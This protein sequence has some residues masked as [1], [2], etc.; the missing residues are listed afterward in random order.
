VL[1]SLPGVPFEMQHL[2]EQVVCKLQERFA[3]A[4]IYHRNL[5]TFGLPEATLAEQLAAWE[6]ALPSYIKLAYL[7][8]PVSGI[9]L[10][11]SVYDKLSVVVQQEVEHQVTALK[12]L[13]GNILYGEELDSLQAVSGRL[14]QAKGATVATA[15]SCTGG[16]IASLITS[17][18]G[19]SA[20]FKGSVIA[21]DNNVKINVLGVAKDSLTLN[22]AVSSEVV[23][24]MAEGARRL[25]QTDY[26]VA[27]SGIAGPDGGTPEKPVG[28]VWTAVASPKGTKTEL[29]HTIGDRQ[30]IIER[31]AANALNLLRLELDY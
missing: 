3:L 27:T 6:N 16:K 5:M 1:I 7:P 30:R 23:Q 24:Q 19:S 13:L 25:L 11:L 10:R 15:E 2:M 28:T 12:Q 21:Y 9:K 4:P 22:G 14:L 17:I 20:Y 26:A 18:A 31:A 8:N 29:L